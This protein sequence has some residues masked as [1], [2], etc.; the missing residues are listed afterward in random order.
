L[1]FDKDHR[2]YDD[3]PHILKSLGVVKIKLLTANPDKINIINNAFHDSRYEHLSVQNNSDHVQKYLDVKHKHFNNIISSVNTSKIHILLA[4]SLYYSEE[5]K[6]L[7][8]KMKYE[9][10]KQYD[11]VIKYNYIIAPGTREIPY[12]VKKELDKNNYDAVFA[13]GICLKGDTDHHNI[14]A[15]AASTGLIQLELQYNL[16]ITTAIIAAKNINIVKERTS[17]SKCTANSL[18][19]TLLQSINI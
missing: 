1:G 10:E 12:Y 6:E 13:V 7:I 9:L 14:I 15:T 11:G 3:I 19:T 4:S 2:N 8:E 18:A 5:C 16:P 17:G